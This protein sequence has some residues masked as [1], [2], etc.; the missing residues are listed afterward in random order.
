MKI[1]AL[2]LLAMPV[3][4]MDQCIQ[5]QS[6]P[7]PIEGHSTVRLKSAT[8]PPLAKD[9][10]GAV[11]T[12]CRVSHF[13][14][15][16]PLV[17]PGQPGAAHLHMFWGNTATDAWTTAETITTIGN[18]TCRGGILNRSA[19]W[20]PA[21]LDGHGNVLSPTGQVNVYYKT[22]YNVGT[23]GDR[24]NEIIQPP[25]EGIRIATKPGAT[26]YEYACAGKK[27]KTFAECAGASSVEIQVRLPQCWDGQNLFD[28]SGNHLAYAVR[29]RGGCPWTHPIALPAIDYVLTY[30]GDPANWRL[31]SDHGQPGGSTMHA[32]WMN[33]WIDGREEIFVREVI[34]QGRDGGSGY[35]GNLEAWF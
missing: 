27:V 15:D 20:I 28:P 23:V 10:V 19:Y 8:V 34:N 14:Y 22:G 3:M 1:L 5:C 4:A 18:G 11:R 12:T 33:G 13:A 29:A 30:E 7:K 9:G 2:L 35:A 21:V 26:W 31:S 24:K 32:D 6:I 17:F 25:P 16:D